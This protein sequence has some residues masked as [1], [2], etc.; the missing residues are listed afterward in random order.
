[1]Y[2]LKYEHID[3]ILTSMEERFSEVD[4]DGSNSFLVCNLN[5]IKTA[6]HLLMLLSQI[7]QYFSIASKRTEE[8]FEKI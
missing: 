8:L 2:Q 3:R 5:P 1:M 7:E 6:C 4:E